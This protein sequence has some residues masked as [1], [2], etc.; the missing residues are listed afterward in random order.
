MI[1]G[2]YATQA[3]MFCQGGG[4]QRENSN[5]VRGWGRICLYWLCLE[6]RDDKQ[7]TKGQIDNHQWQPQHWKTPLRKQNKKCWYQG[8]FFQETEQHYCPIAQRILSDDQEKNLPHD[9]HSNERIIVFRVINWRRE[10]R[11][12]FLFHEIQRKRHEQTNA[13]AM[14]NTYFANFM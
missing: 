12:C 2:R 11:S 10:V 9:G 1:S 6:V 7:K 5:S 8:H 3:V 14:R 4:S 13:P